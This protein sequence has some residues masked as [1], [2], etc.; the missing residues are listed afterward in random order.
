[1]TDKHIN[2]TQKLMNNKYK[3]VYGLKLTLTLHKS[4]KFPVRCTKNFLQIIHC[5]TNHWVVA[6]TILSHPKVVVYDSLFS[7]VDSNTTSIL[8]QLFGPKVKV[9]V[10]NDRKQVG[11]EECGLFAIANCI[12]LAERS[13]PAN[14][15]DQPKMRLHLIKCIEYLNVTAFPYTDN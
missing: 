2:F 13:L 4:T 14:N 1:M 8:K 15:Y 10:N 11:A 5:R 12:C 9:M 3:N 6:S 7:S